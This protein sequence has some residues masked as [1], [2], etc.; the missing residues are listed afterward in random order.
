[1]FFKHIRDTVLFPLY[2]GSGMLTN[3]YRYRCKSPGAVGSEFCDFYCV[4]G[5]WYMYM[6]AIRGQP[7]VNVPLKLLSGFP[8][9][10]LEAAA[11]FKRP[12]HL[13]GAFLVLTGNKS[14]EGPIYNNICVLIY[15]TK[16]I[17]F[18]VKIAKIKL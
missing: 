14:A 12:V 11:R 16:V 1:M 6:Q 4:S 17:L 2:R 3:M 9:S 13:A 5:L 18:Q 8:F 15:E 7:H 10:N